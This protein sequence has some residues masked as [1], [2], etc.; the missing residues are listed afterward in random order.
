MA[1]SGG[2]KTAANCCKSTYILFAS[3]MW[4]KSLS[5]N[6]VELRITIPNCDR[7]GTE[8]QEICR[9]FSPQ[10]E[11][12]W[13][14]TKKAPSGVCF[15]RTCQFQTPEPIFDS[16]FD[17]ATKCAFGLELINHAEGNIIREAPLPFWAN[18]GCVQASAAHPEAFELSSGLRNAVVRS[19]TIVFHY[20]CQCQRFPDPAF[21]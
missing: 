4:S 16:F 8:D 18:L 19:E 15:P 20:E 17:W 21:K 3:Y 14:E 9:T 13:L 10:F 5:S 1:D 6:R 12:F 2:S 11:R 7:Q